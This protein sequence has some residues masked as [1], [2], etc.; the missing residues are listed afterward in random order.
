MG[1]LFE[2][3]T[4]INRPN[5]LASL[6]VSSASPVVRS[7]GQ[8]RHLRRVGKTDQNKN[9]KNPQDNGVMRSW[10]GEYNY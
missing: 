3:M 4:R 5:P 6:L 2:R 7:F 8:N 10:E 1:V 9:K